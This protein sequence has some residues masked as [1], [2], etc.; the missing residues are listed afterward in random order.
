MWLLTQLDK[1][2]VKLSFLF[3]LAGDGDCSCD[4][5][6]AYAEGVVHDKD[7]RSAPFGLLGE[8]ALLAE[9]TE[10]DLN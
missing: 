4:G 9:D 6:L 3:S 5:L 8:E 7:A 2:K 10:A 1:V